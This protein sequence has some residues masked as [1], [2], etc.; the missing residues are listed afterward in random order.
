MSIGG[1]WNTVAGGEECEGWLTISKEEKNPTNLSRDEKVEIR[2][3]SNKVTVRA[4]QVFVTVLACSCLATLVLCTHQ[5]DELKVL[6]TT[7]LTPS[8]HLSGWSSWQTLHV[9]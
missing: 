6:P 8:S 1:Q 4:E 7:S 2:V 3:W 5:K 9:T